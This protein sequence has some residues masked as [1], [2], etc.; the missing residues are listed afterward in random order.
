MIGP[1]TVDERGLVASRILPDG[2]EA[3]VAP[4]VGSK[5]R[6]TVGPLGAGVYDEG[7]EYGT[8]DG[9][10]EAMDLWDPE[11]EEEPAGWVRHVPSM[12]RRPGGDPKREYVLPYEGGNR[13]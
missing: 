13:G 11:T 6:L 7:W 10:I 5:G 3:A 8:L 9:A 12:R 4:L 1:Y 2:R